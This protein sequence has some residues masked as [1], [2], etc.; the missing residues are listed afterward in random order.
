MAKDFNNGFNF[1]T[2]SGITPNMN[3]ISWPITTEDVKNHL[4]RKIEAAYDAVNAKRKAE[5]KEGVGNAPEIVVFTYNMS[6]TNKFCPLVVAIPRSAYEVGKGNRNNIPKIYRN[7][8]DEGNTNIMI[9]P[10]VYNVLKPYMYNKEEGKT[11]IGKKGSLARHQVDMDAKKGIE[12][13]KYTKISEASPTK[14]K[15]DKCCMFIINNV[16][17]FHDMLEMKN[18]QGGKAFRVEIEKITK[19][20]DGAYR[21]DVVRNTSKG[22]NNQKDTNLVK[23]LSRYMA[24]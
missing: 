23:S 15:N 9:D 21:Y 24:R 6:R 1:E 22:K 12:F 3:R 10:I 17:V 11:F 19:I 5:G 16:A 13:A 20:Q 4:Q 2:K 7:M 8:D 14:N 18:N